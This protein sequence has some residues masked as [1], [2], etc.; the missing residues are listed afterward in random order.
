[1]RIERCNR[2]KIVLGLV[3]ALS[4]LPGALAYAS[5]GL[6]AASVRLT[7]S[8][9]AAIHLD[10]NFAVRQVVADPMLHRR[11]AIVENCAH[12]ERPLKMIQLGAPISPARGKPVRAA[13]TIPVAAAQIVPAMA[14]R[15]SQITVSE[16]VSSPALARFRSAAPLPQPLLV[17]AG[18][19]VHLWSASTNVRLEIEAIALDYGHAGQVIHLRRTGNDPSERVML[20]GLVD[21][22][23][24]AE[25]LP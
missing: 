13:Q 9:R 19:L 5:G 21:G 7:I 23:D 8:E 2:R 14:T 22:T 15:A 17:R 3:M 4:M 10:P 20:A 1:M 11:W 12:P 24:T 18:D 16:A 25:L 6:C